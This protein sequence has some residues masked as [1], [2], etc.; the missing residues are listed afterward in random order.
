MFKGYIALDSDPYTKNC[1]LE[2]RSSQV[3]DT[4]VAKTMDEKI[5]SGNLLKNF[6]KRADSSDMAY[7]SPP[8]FSCCFLEHNCDG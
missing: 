8:L 1:S 5:H 2:T 4:V 3:F 6:L 7:L